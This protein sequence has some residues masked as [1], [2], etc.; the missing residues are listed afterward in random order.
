[1]ARSRRRRPIFGITTSETEKQDKRL[2]NRR[3]RRKVRVAVETGDEVLPVL[4][5]VS[6]VWGFDKDG[7]RWCWGIGEREMRK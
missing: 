2:A 4:R 5:E 6:D 7:K 1:M 3:L